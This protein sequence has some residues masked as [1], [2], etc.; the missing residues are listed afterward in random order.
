MPRTFRFNVSFDATVVASD[1]M[2]TALTELRADVAANPAEYPAVM[3][4]IA[5]N[6]KDAEL[7]AFIES[8]LR[9]NYR[10]SLK[11]LGEKAHFGEGHTL[12]TA[13]VTRL[14]TPPVR[15]EEPEPYRCENHPETCANP[16]CTVH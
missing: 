6:T 5:Q 1:E 8:L 13:K 12:S 3:I 9:T 7:E 16:R 11:R 4:N 15:L 2:V 14:D 10:A